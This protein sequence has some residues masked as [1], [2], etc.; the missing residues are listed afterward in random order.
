MNRSV[1]DDLEYIRDLAESGARAP[2]LG[3]R[4]LVWWGALVTLAYGAHYLMIQRIAGLQPQYIPWMWMG[5]LVLG[6]G[7]FFLLLALSPKSKPGR[8]SPGNQAEQVVWMF[9][10]FSIFAFF[11]G[12]TMGQLLPGAGEPISPNASLPMVFAVYAV[13]LA[14]TGHLADNGA[15]KLAG[16]AALV[17]V[18]FATAMQNRPELYLVGAAGAF[19]T[20]LLPGIALWRAEPKTTV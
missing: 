3:G 20:V 17:I 16:W 12:A 9:A 7:G 4:Y 10:G 18:G 2:L 8:G 1:N 11:V 6:L 15:M 5:F 14:V 13:S 19:F